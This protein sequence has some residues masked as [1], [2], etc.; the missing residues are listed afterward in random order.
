MNRNEASRVARSSNLEAGAAFERRLYL[1][2]RLA[3]PVQSDTGLMSR[4][5]R[6]GVQPGASVTVGRGGEGLLVGSGGEVTEISDEVATAYP[7]QELSFGPDYIIPKPFDPRLMGVVASAVARQVDRVNAD[8]DRRTAERLEPNQ[9]A[10]VF[11]SGGAIAR[12]VI[13]L[14]GGSPHTWAQLNPVTVNSS[15]TK[16][17]VGRRGTTLVSFNDHSHLEQPGLVTYR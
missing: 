8:L 5:R 4:L 2:R 3:E 14:L 9:T 6:A 11:T 16:V 1:V 10:V 15:V 17:V 7:G 12:V 13:S